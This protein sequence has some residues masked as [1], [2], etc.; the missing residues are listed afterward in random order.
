[1]CRA[2]NTPLG[3]GVFQSLVLCESGKPGPHLQNTKGENSSV[4]GTP[5]TLQTT[6]GVT[7]DP[8]AFILM[9]EIMNHGF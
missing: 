9:N 7:S 2:M 4:P 1:M 8:V 6:D 3:F 5:P